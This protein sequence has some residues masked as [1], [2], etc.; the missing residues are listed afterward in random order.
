MDTQLWMD[1]GPYT[2]LPVLVECLVPS[3]PNKT[4]FFDLLGERLFTQSPRYL[5]IGFLVLVGF[6]G[7]R[8]CFPLLLNSILS[9]NNLLRKTV[10]GGRGDIYTFSYVISPDSITTTFKIQ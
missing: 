8:C 5:I 2:G 4:S 1:F 10:G 7:C 3:R 9:T 6:V